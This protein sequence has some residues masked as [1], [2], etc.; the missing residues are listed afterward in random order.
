MPVGGR[1]GTGVG[2]TLQ[3]VLREAAASF[4]EA[5]RRLAAKTGSTPHVAQVLRDVLN[6]EGLA[7]AA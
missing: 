3:R 2:Q 6:E 1:E 5:R 4:E 7:S